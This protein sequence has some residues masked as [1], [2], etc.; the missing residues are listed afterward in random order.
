MRKT[1]SEQKWTLRAILLLGVLF[2][3]LP[4]LAQR[5]PQRSAAGEAAIQAMREYNQMS[6]KFVDALPLQPGDRVAVYGM[7]APHYLKDFLRRI[8]PEGKI[9]A[10]FRAESNYRYE[11]EQGQSVEDPR[12]HPI[13]AADG[14]AHLEPDVIDMA[15]AMDLF[16]F[17]RREHDLYRE[18]HRALRVGGTLVQVRA[19]RRTEA[20]FEQRHPKQ[21]NQLSG[22]MLLQETNRQRLGVTQ[23]GFRYVDEIPLF[24]TRTVRLYE[25]LE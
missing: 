7:S 11:L 25:N 23:H 15:I 1:L 22:R 14:D 13:F 10:V 17:Y 20:E 2:L 18:A 21:R 4:A 6:R 12:I 9:Y 3:G 8:G 24:D 19:T 16:G 5:A